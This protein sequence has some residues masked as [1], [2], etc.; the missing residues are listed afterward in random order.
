MKVSLIME[1]M[2]E[3]VFL[4]HLR[5]F[6]QPRLS[7]KMP[8]LDPVL[9]K[10]RIPTAEKLRRQVETLLSIGKEP[11]DAVIALTDVYTGSQP[12]D[13][14]DA[15]DAKAKMRRWI[16]ENERFHPHAAQHDFE[17]WLL[18]YWERIQ[19]LAKSNR[20]CPGS[21]PE[22]VNHM[23]P[24]AHQLQDVFSKGG[25]GHGYV[26]T[27]DADRILRGQDLLVAANAC[28]ELKALL[29]TILC[30]CSGEEAMIP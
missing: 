19:K 23:K 5:A 6:L 24:P 9:Y 28:R 1:G 17:A 26:K 20:A 11:A 25:H 18:P 22:R 10:G 7:G 16:G 27:R 29:N 21:N 13:F 3:K 14:A 2:T 15:A 30:L 4:P 12:P 8:K